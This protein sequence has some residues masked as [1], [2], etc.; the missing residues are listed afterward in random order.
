MVTQTELDKSRLAIAILQLGNAINDLA[1]ALRFAGEN[2]REAYKF[3]VKAKLEARNAI[4]NLGEIKEP[5]P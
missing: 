1:D 5:R 3:I 2:D 4:D